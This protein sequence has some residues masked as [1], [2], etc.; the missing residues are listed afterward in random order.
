MNKE[1]TDVVGI[2]YEEGETPDIYQVYGSRLIDTQSM[3]YGDV[4]VG[5]MMDTTLTMGNLKL[6]LTKDGKVSGRYDETVVEDGVEYPYSEAYGG[7]YTVDGEFMELY[8]NGDVAKFLIIDN[9][10]ENV[11]DGV[12][13]LYYEKIS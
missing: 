2:I 3:Y 4:K 12:A 11:A 6:K 8:L 1:G 7:N 13:S 9:E 5:E 10:D